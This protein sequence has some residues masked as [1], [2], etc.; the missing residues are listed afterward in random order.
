MV[1]MSVGCVLLLV[2]GL[3]RG[4]QDRKHEIESSITEIC[5]FPLKDIPTTLGGWKVVEG[6]ERTL[7]PLTMRITGAS[8]YIMPPTSMS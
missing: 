6:G 1:W 7:D 5:P 3:A 4:F 8:E 2:S